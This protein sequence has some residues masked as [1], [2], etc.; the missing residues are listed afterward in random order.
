VRA[1]VNVRNKQLFANGFAISLSR[2]KRIMLL[3][4]GKASAPMLVAVS[5]ILTGFDVYGVLVAPRNEAV[6]VADERIEVFR[7]DHPVPDRQ[8]MIAAQH[9]IDALSRMRR[10][11]LLICLISGGA[12]AMLPA[13]PDGISLADLRKLTTQLIMSKATIHEINT[14]RRHVSKLNGGRLVK[15]CRASK[16][17]SLIISDV[18]GD[19]LPDIASG[20]TVE[21]PSSYED[22]VEVLKSHYLWASIPKSARDH[23][24]RGVRHRIP[25]T[26]KPG[27]P[28]FLRVHNLIIAGNRTACIAA[29]RSLTA[30][31]VTSVILS[32]SAE[33]DAQD[34]GR[35]LASL[36]TEHERSNGSVPK[37][38]A[39]IMGGETTVEVKG[40]GMGG[41]NQETALWAVDKI[42][43]LEGV[44]IAALG[45]DGID[46][47]ST[48]AGALTDGDSARRA[49]EKRMDPP[50]FLSRN[51][52]Y[53]FFR[54]LGDNII[55][56]P[57]GTNVGD[58]YLMVAYE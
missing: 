52:S 3:A 39:F 17:L 29:R 7:S 21:D 18:P 11:E 5:D 22:A 25:D 55:T 40:R 51:D 15:L 34:M 27:D 48:A 38:E 58:L 50:K 37:A 54:R 6:G 23:L 12:S 16:I 8:G 4:V 41:R 10:E 32:S 1:Q 44:A 30:K 24:S 20:L 31:K 9:V 26:P 19:P 42:A 35:F 47:S 53:D 56:G 46:G 43:G 13:P 45:T 36:A 2:F 33:M 57:T 49:S 28:A 14:V